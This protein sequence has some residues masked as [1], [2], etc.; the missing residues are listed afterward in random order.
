MTDDRRVAS[1]YMG[2][3]KLGTAARYNLA[4]SGLADLELGDL[5]MDLARL[6]LHGDNPYGW[7]PLRERI[8]A[9]FGVGPECVV[10]AAGASFANH[11]ALAALIAPGD[12]VLIEAPTYPLLTDALAYFQARVRTF[13]RGFA[14]GWRLDP[15]AVANRLTSDTRLVVLTNPHNPSGAQASDE[16]VRAIA[17]AAE[18]VGAVVLVDEVYRELTFAAGEAVTVFEPSRNLVV[19]SSLT[20]AYGLSGLRC[21]WILAPPALA[22]RMRRLDD[23]FAARGPHLMEQLALAAFDRLD[24]L[25]QS[26]RVIVETN[27]A[28][29]REILANHPCLEQIIFDQGTTVFPRLRVAMT[30]AFPSRLLRDHETSVAPGRFFG[31]PDHVRVGLGADPASTRAGLERFAAAL[32]EPPGRSLRPGE[33]RP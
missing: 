18:R 3:A 25:R 16:A 33:P 9:R 19:T 23:L 17:E 29:Y 7:P 31:A 20:K 32:G 4:G 30:D 11:L 6:R 28:A 8:G 21:G 22:E 2:F 15:A 26:A 24:A 14:E 10:T 27:R 5:E 1:D 12:Q 13:P